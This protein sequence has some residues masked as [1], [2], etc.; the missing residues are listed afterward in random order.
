MRLTGFLTELA[1]NHDVACCVPRLAEVTRRQL[2][3]LGVQG[4]RADR[5]LPAARAGLRLPLQVAASTPWRVP[6]WLLR[7]ADV[8]HLSTVRSVPLVPPSDLP[9]AH[10]D[11]VDALSRNTEDRARYSRFSRFWQREA[12]LLG[13]YERTVGARARSVSCTSEADCEAIG[14]PSALVI[15]FGVRIP[16]NL[17]CQDSQPTL[18]FPGN[19]GYFPNVDAAVHLATSIFPLVRRSIKDARLLLVGARPTARVCALAEL[20]GVEVHR[21]VPEMTTYFGRAWVVVAPLRYG[22][23]LQTKVLEAFAHCRPVVTSSGVAARVPGA[24]V[25]QHLEAADD[26]HVVGDLVAGLLRDSHRRGLLA[27]AGLDIAR[28]LTWDACARQL[29]RAYLA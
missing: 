23:G 20:E 5:T 6:T 7:D 13:A 8:I 18:L 11:F 25:G 12:A 22:T 27:S 1:R 3:E 29:E 24:V 28:S 15:P 2:E 19:L 21:D 10:L 17:P 16:S 4:V 14:L 26:P 9:R